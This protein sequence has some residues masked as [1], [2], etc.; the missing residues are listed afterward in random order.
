MNEMNKNGINLSVLAPNF[1][2]YYT[3]ALTDEYRV[4]FWPAEDGFNPDKD[5]EKAL[6]LRIF[7]EF[8]EHKWFR[9]NIGENFIYR[10]L[11]DSSVSEGIYEEPIEEYQIL[12]IDY[13]G[14]YDYTYPGYVKMSK[15]GRFYLPVR[16][17]EDVVKA[18]CVRIKYYIPREAVHAYVKDWR[19]A[20]FNGS[21]PG[22]VETKNG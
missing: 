18:P 11:D 20:G 19:L 17:E 14:R 3:A 13:S 12:D 16:E 7:N 6:E 1:R 2:G 4:G 5:Q 21:L 15:G 9:G 8:A 10:K 22:K